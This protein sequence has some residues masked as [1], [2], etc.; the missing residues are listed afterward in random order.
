ML[1]DAEVKTNFISLK[2]FL[3]L[4]ISVADVFSMVS[5][6]VQDVDFNGESTD[7]GG[8]VS[9]SES[10]LS[11]SFKV[12]NGKGAFNTEPFNDI[13]G[14]LGASGEYETGGV[15][16]SLWSTESVFNVVFWVILVSSSSLLDLELFSVDISST[17]IDSIGGVSSFLTLRPRPVEADFGVVFATLTG[18]FKG[19]LRGV[20]LII[21]VVSL[22]GVTCE[23]RDRR[24]LLASET[25]FSKQK[26]I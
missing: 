21:G 5:S 24:L 14:V 19:V 9:A 15:L 8:L 12:D 7:F 1:R 25:I 18:V 2:K 6:S 22:A 23:V 26:F 16:A 13:S 17:S 3:S 4:S 10:V 11:T 20:F